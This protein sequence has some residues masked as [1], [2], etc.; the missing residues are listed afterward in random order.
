MNDEYHTDKQPEMAATGTPPDASARPSIFARL[1]VAA[2][3]LAVLAASVAGAMWLVKNR[4]EAERRRPPSRARLVSVTPLAAQTRQVMVDAMGTVIPARQIDLAAQV[5]GLVTD[6]NPR[7]VPGGR[8]QAGE[9]MLKIERDDYEL[10]LRQRESELARA[11]SNL[12]IEMGQQDVAVSEFELLGEDITED[13][14]ELVLRQPQLK[15]AEAQVAAAQAAVDKAKL[16]L[17]RTTIGAPFNAVIQNRHVDVGAQVREGATLATLAGTDEYWI[18]VSVPVYELKW[19]EIPEFNSDRGSEVHVYYESAWSPGVARKGRVAR[20]LSDLE[21][22]GR[23]ARLLVTVEDPLQLHGD[24][25]ERRPL[26]LGSYVRVE[27]AG[28]PVEN[29]MPIPRTAFHEGNQIW[30]MT[31]ER[32]LDIRAV[33][34]VWTTKDT[35]YARDHIGPGELLVTSDL[36]S[37]VEGMDLRVEG[38]NGELN[39]ADS[40]ADAG[41]AQTETQKRTPPA[42][43]PQG[44]GKTVDGNQEE[45]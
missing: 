34:P 44:P 13:D 21:T 10:A 2:L 4:P 9:W 45:E 39:D 26:I 20:L 43:T 35:I 16:D 18:E 37:P 22:Q 28:R 33:S 7:F 41:A 24:P 27:I 11:R 23:M 42:A 29:V 32:T 14:R 8:F 30:I 17:Q 38:E 5:G 12:Q 36:G 25:G 3:A 40:A 6:A 19:L 15:I 1:I 31:P